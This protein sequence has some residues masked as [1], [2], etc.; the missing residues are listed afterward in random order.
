M[1]TKNELRKKFEKEYEKYYKVKFFEENGFIRKKC[2][3]CGKHFWTLDPDRKY[4]GEPP[5][6]SYAFINNPPTKKKYDYIE[7]WR[8]FADY[9]KKLGHTEIK[10][11]PV[12][13]RWR[14][15]L[16]F[17]IASISDFQPYVVRGEVE[18]PANPL[19]VPQVCLRFGDIPNV[20]VTGR[21]FTSFIMNGQH[22]FNT[23]EKKIYWKNETLEM[24]FK[25]LTE[26]MGIPPEEIVAKEA[27]W[28]G[29]G[30]FGPSMEYIIRGLE[31]VNQVFMQFEETPDGFRE[32]TTRVI[33]VGWGH[34]R[35]AWISTGD[36]TAYDTVFGPVI[37]RLIKETGISIDQDLLLKYSKLAGDL[38]VAE[39]KNI[40][41]LWHKIANNLNMPLTELKESLYPLTALYSIADHVRTLVFAITDGALPS[42]VGGGYNLRVILRRALSFIENLK[43]DITLEDVAAWH[44]DYLKDWFPELAE[45]YDDIVKIFDIE[46]KRFYESY[47]RAKRIVTNLLKKSKGELSPQKI[48]ELYISH[49]ITPEII[50]ETIKKEKLSVKLPAN[51]YSYIAEDEFERPKRKEK[52]EEKKEELFVDSKILEALPPTR[53]LYYEDMYLQEFKAKVL[54]IVN[55]KYVILDQTAFYPEGGGQPGDIGTLE[56]SKV[57]DTKKIGQVVI[58]IVDKPTFSEGDEIDGKI[59]WNRRHEL[60]KHHTATHILLGST[61]RI[62]GR[63]VWQWGSQ[64]DTKISRLDITHYDT[65]SLKE[66]EEIEKAANQVVMENRRVTVTFMPRRKAEDLYGFRL[67]QGGVVPGREIRVLK[68]EDWDVEACG[69]THLKSTGE[70]GQL[71]IVRVKR[72]QDGVVRIEFAAGKSALEFM[73]RDRRLLHETSKIL[74]VEE[75]KIPET[76]KRFFEEWK[77]LN[78]EVRKLKKELAK[79]YS[80][81]IIEKAEEIHNIKIFI[82]KFSDGD[83]KT[84][85]DIGNELKKKNI[86]L[87]GLLYSVS[88][89]VCKW[90]LVSTVNDA[91]T[92]TIAEKIAKTIQGGFG[93]ISDNLYQG[94]GKKSI[95]EKDVWAILKETIDRVSSH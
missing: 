90:I 54:K 69:G 16:Y 72:I 68:V 58:H 30:N 88:N 82:Q 17:T 34:E 41:E 27:V 10:R 9:F 60:M 31:V 4:C 89:N 13:A 81:Q 84:L 44:I 25:F 71:R 33:D 95:Q 26:V 75:T 36:P 93:K 39:V 87:V 14:D 5:C 55:N 92:R 7:M 23:P 86:D 11:Y 50:Q 59:D 65:L 1:V 85:I 35:L 15:D 61:R 67:Y 94:G 12:V 29:G 49:G 6:G 42:N 40:D 2:P 80:N 18:P 43:F 63:H 76:A 56:N 64:L 74:R 21:H 46:E 47:K 48:R 45:A 53:K 28:V 8:V 57:L 66:I 37:K 62:L 83:G 24:N 19:I 3:L 70:I 77:S 22:A 20:G 32:L 79:I 91:T 78:K 52:K 73:H 51:V 38:D